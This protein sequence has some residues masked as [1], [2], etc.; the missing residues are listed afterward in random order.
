MPAWFTFKAA[1]R[2]WWVLP[3]LALGLWSWRLDTLRAR[4]LKKEQTAELKLSISNTSLNQCNAHI[5]DNN[6]R[7]SEANARLEQTKQQ[8]AADVARANARWEETGARVKSLQASARDKTQ[9]PCKVSEI[10][11]KGLEGL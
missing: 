4:H 7:I 10:A 5:A 8:A 11:L 3:I 9:P 1:L 2:F 6:R